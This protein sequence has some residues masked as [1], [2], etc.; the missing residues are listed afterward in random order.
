NNNV[1]HRGR[2]FH[3]QTEDSGVKNPR[4]VTHLFADGGR[5][6]KTTRTEYAE[7][8]A[9]PDMQP[10]VRSLMK[11]QHKGMFMALRMGELDK[12]LEDV[13][14]PFEQPLQ[15]SKA[16]PAPIV[17]AAPPPPEPLPL[18]TEPAPAP[19][20]ETP[21]IASAFGD[22][23]RTSDRA[24]APRPM[25]NPNLRKVV[26]SVPPPAAAAF[27]L[28]V[29]A[30]ERLPPKPAVPSLDASPEPGSIRPL[31][32]SNPPPRKLRPNPPSAAA[33]APPSLS[34]PSSRFAAAP[35]KTSQ[36]IFGDGVISEQSLDEVILS[37]LAEDLDSSE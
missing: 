15:L 36:S 8:V 27:E 23:D 32:K 31:R 14:G 33:N 7:H 20:F 29:A 9:R 30:L 13:C 6:I 25:S 3:I 34:R 24:E 5:I 12:L 4:I 17:S 10:F 2:I 35:T 1:R 19:D 28:D 18:L 16:P 37:Y 21:A 26:P 11:E 22:S